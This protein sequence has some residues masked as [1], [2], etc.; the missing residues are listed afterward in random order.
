MMILAQHQDK[1]DNMTNLD[2]DDNDDDNNEDDDYLLSD[3]ELVIKNEER[4]V[5]LELVFG[6][7]S[8]YVPRKDPIDVKL[9]QL[10]QKSLHDAASNQRLASS[11][12]TQQEQQ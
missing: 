11:T 1:E 8:E 2:D 10:I 5:M 12:T 6:P 9:K 4:K 3:M 7:Q